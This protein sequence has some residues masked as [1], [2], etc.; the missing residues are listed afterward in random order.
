MEKKSIITGKTLE[1]AKG[2]S[3]LRAGCTPL[4]GTSP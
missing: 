4:D 2:T 1:E 3:C